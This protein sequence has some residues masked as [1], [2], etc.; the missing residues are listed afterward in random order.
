[1]VKAQ[2]SKTVLKICCKLFLIYLGIK[3]SKIER[4]GPEKPR[5]LA[6]WLNNLLSNPE[7]GNVKERLLIPV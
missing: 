5:R 2:A 3:S 1:M 6:G 4:F 7:G